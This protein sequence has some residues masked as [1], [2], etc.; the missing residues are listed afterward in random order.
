MKTFIYGFVFTLVIIISYVLVVYF[1]SPL[2]AFELIREDGIIEHAQLGC[3]FLS[4]VLLIYLSIISRSHT[5]RSRFKT[6]RNYFYIL[7][8]IFSILI[9]GEEIS[10][11]QRLFDVKTPEKLQEAGG[12]SLHNRNYLFHI[13]GTPITAARI[14]FPVIITYFALIPIIS[15]V[16]IKAHV[17]LEGIGLPTV[18]ILLAILV[19]VNFIIW[20]IVFRF[21][22][23]PERWDGLPDYAFFQTA[24]EVYEM[25]FALLLLWSSISFY[26]QRRYRRILQT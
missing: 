23:F 19:L 20:Q 18:P 17:L 16:S 7:L 10:W 11:G 21:F 2:I 24:E 8:G 15:E 22:D 25:N 12:I 3:Y 13:F 1:L 6:K 4:A 26:F 5:V 9:L 14:Y